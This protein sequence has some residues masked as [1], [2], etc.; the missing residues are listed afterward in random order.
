VAVI[1]IKNGN[2]KLHQWLMTSAI[3]LSLAFSDVRS[4]YMTSD[5]TN[6]GEGVI[7]YVYIIYNYPHCFV[8]S[9]HSDGLVTMFD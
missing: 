9:Y 2:R 8:N 7:K 3:A 6:C 5:S 1:A 4:V